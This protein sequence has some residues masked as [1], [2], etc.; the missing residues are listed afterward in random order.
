M[1]IRPFKFL[2]AMARVAWAKAR[3]YR[4][5]ATEEEAEDRLDICLD[6]PFLA[7]ES[8][9]RCKICTCFV[10]AKVLLTTE[11]CPKKKWLAIWSKKIRK[12]A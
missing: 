8:N 6:C 2:M 7:P 12:I 5:L 11:E 9:Y 3:G 1:R 4:T 10:E